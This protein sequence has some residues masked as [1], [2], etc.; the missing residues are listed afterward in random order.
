M[1]SGWNATDRSQ[2]AAPG[3]GFTPNVIAVRHGLEAMLTA[4]EPGPPSSC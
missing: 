1:R 4:G 2:G 3:Q